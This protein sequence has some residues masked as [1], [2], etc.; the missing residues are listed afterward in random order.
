MQ[1]IQLLAIKAVREEPQ[2]PQFVGYW[3]SLERAQG[4][5][6]MSLCRYI[7]LASQSDCRWQRKPPITANADRASRCQDYS[8]PSLLSILIRPRSAL[9]CAHVGKR[10]IM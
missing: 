4:V 8:G 1:V 10:P 9:N 6:L 2:G 3:A 7:N 5:L